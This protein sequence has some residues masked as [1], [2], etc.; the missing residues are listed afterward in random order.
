MIPYRYYTWTQLVSRVLAVHTLAVWS[1][2]QTWLSHFNILNLKNNFT[3]DKKH[4][5][6]YTQLTLGPIFYVTMAQQ[7]PSGP[8][9]PHCW[10]FMITLRHTTTGRTPLD[11]WSARRRDLYRTTH[12]NHKRQTSTPRRDS[13]PQSQQA[14]GHRPHVLD[15][16]ATGSASSILKGHNLLCRLYLVSILSEHQF[17]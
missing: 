2:A 17:L 11:E 14:S 9:L 12:N 1:D 13:N 4:F 16:A 5:L 8:R 6:S 15:R 7:P 3:R 10:G